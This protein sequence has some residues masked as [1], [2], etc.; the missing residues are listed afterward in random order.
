MK[1]FIGK[2]YVYGVIPF[3]AESFHMPYSRNAVGAFVL[4]TIG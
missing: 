3:F 2:G 4:Y 1:K